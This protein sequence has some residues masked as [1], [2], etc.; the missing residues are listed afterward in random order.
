MEKVNNV[1]RILAHHNI[2]I[3]KMVSPDEEVQKAEV[4]KFI[5][6]LHDT[7]GMSSEDI[8]KYMLEFKTELLNLIDDMDD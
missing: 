5:T 6:Y 7:K 8:D 2:D 4:Q 1:K 3:N